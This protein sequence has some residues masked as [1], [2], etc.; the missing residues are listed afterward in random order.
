VLRKV[1]IKNY[2]VFNKFVLDL[3]PG[4]NI[5]V[6]DNDAGKSTCLRPST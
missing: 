6:G 1:L 3:S 4:V 2:R 5:I